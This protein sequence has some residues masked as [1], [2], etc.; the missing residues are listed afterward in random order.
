MKLLERLW[1]RAKTGAD[2][3]DLGTVEETIIRFKDK[4][5][6]VMENPEGEIVSLGW[7]YDNELHTHVPVKDFWTASQSQNHTLT[8]RREDERPTLSKP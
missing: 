2:I 4:L 1:F 3:V 7:M 8:N 5:I 6:S